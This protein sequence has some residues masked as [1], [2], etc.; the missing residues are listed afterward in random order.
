MSKTL[1]LW[2]TMKRIE[3]TALECRLTLRKH[4]AS[5]GPDPAGRQT[6]GCGRQGYKASPNGLWNPLPLKWGVVPVNITDGP[7]LAESRHLRLPCSCLERGQALR[8]VALFCDRPRDWALRAGTRSRGDPSFS[9]R[10]R[11]SGPQQGINSTN[12]VDHL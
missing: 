5:L 8:T 10:K 6:K 3:N 4:Q 11:P 1:F 2:K 12:S 7:S 9:W